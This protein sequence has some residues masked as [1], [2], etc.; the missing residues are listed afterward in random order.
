MYICFHINR[1]FHFKIEYE[2]PETLGSDRIAAVAGAFSLFPGSEVLIVDAG[3]ALT[4]EFLSAEY[5]QGGTI[6][7]GLTMRFKALN[8][9][10]EDF[11]WYLHRQL[12]I[13]GAKYY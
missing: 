7:P 6:S 1:G 8:K 5:I 4:F 9:F 10:T 13:P 12:L 2:T 11:R 3:T